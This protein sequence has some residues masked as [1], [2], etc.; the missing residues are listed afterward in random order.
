MLEN[1]WI[2]Y[3]FIG[4]LIGMGSMIFVILFA[5][6]KRFKDITSRMIDNTK[7]LLKEMDK[8]QEKIKK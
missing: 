7:A 8:M 6:E 2:I 3:V 1:T 5:M 4:I